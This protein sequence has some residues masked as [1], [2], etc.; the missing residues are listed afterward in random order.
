MDLDLH[1]SWHL[2]V[3][4]IRKTVFFRFSPILHYFHTVALINYWQKFDKTVFSVVSWLA[5]IYHFGLHWLFSRLPPTCSSFE[6]LLNFKLQLL[7]HKWKLEK[8]CDQLMCPINSSLKNSMTSWYVLLTV[9]G[10]SLV[11]WAQFMLYNKNVALSETSFIAPCDA[12]LQ[13][14]WA[15]HHKLSSEWIPAFTALLEWVQ[16][17]R[18]P[19]CLFTICLSVC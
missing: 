8:F 5:I 7:S 1:R 14:P 4:K 17:W 10:C 11:S 15:V 6:H 16:A 12:Y 3:A 18:C 19:C 13:R 2:M 9:Y